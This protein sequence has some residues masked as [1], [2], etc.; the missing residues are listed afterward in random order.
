MHACMHTCIHTY[1][2]TYI[3]AY[4]HT[5]IHAYTHTYIQVDITIYI[6]IYI[7]TPKKDKTVVKSD[8]AASAAQAPARMDGKSLAAELSGASP[9]MESPQEKVQ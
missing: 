2:H 1:I 9:V 3:H 7:T 5:R 6:Y 4:T 8:S